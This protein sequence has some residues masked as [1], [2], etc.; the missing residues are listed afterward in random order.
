MSQTQENNDENTPFIRLES[1]PDPSLVKEIQSKKDVI[2][3]IES[4]RSIQQQTRMSTLY[5]RYW[6]DSS[7]SSKKDGNNTDDNYIRNLTVLQF[8]ILAEG[9][10]SGPDICPPFEN[11]KTE[12]GSVYGGFTDIP[13][14]EICLDFAL[15]K[16]RVMEVILGGDN[17]T[18]GTYDIIALEEVDRYYGFFQPMLNLFQYDS[19]FFP[20]QNSPGSNQGWFSDGCALFWKRE[21]FELIDKITKSYQVGKNQIYII[22][23][24]H[25]RE[26]GRKLIVATTHLKAKQNSTNEQ[27]R[28][29]QVEELMNRLNE[30]AQMVAIEHDMPVDEIPIILMGD[31]NADPDGDGNTCIKSVLCKSPNFRSAYDLDDQFF[32]TWK[33]RGDKTVRH[34]IDYIFYNNV[35]GFKCS[36]VLNIPDDKE[37]EP[38]KLPGFRH[39]SDHLNIGAKFQL[40]CTQ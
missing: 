13:H 5:P 17:Y 34:V 9:L 1:Q 16:W 32:T 15:R 10:S 29:C 31:F 36:Q 40:T 19:I 14:P 21:K 4:V 11:E 8:N 30:K 26:T 20:K 18:D 33:T 2:N 12:T 37:I 25:H 27:I 39:P 22:L 7:T 6:I 35:K 24:L 38:T 28:T 23:T 3:K